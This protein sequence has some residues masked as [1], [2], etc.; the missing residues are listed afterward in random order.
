[1]GCNVTISGILS[2]CSASKG[3]ILT[4]IFVSKSNAL[5]GIANSNYYGNFTVDP[6]KITADIAK[7]FE[8]NRDTSSFTSTLN[9]DTTNGIK[10]VS[11]EIVLQFNRIS[12]SK[13][14][15]LN[16]ILKGE[17]TVF[18]EDANKQ[19]YCFGWKDFDMTVASSGTG[20]TGGARSDG[21]YYQVTLTCETAMFPCPTDDNTTIEALNNLSKKKVTPE[22]V[23]A[24]L[25]FS[26]INSSSYTGQDSAGVSVTSGSSKYDV[27]TMH[28][29]YST[30]KY[31]SVSIRVA[32]DSGETTQTTSTA[33]SYKYYSTNNYC[34]GTP[35]TTDCDLALSYAYLGADRGSAIPV[36][37]LKGSAEIPVVSISRISD[38]AAYFYQNGGTEYNFQSLYIYEDSGKLYYQYQ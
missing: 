24:K 25:S 35:T 20:Q 37:D 31:Y 8:P 10:Y 12:A 33:T 32:K 6:S 30:S 29:A 21:N 16:N 38:T 14:T 17:W 27:Y 36:Y 5:N 3:G 1:M 9:V 26:S 23:V 18:I 19:W 28:L 13:R 2:D 22:P 7:V 4:S 11:T 34:K 15:E